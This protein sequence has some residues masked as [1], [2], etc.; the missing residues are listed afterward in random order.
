M[1]ELISDR[2]TGFHVDI[3]DPQQLSHTV[4]R[5]WSRPLETR[6]M[7]RAARHHVLEHYSSQSNYNRL[8]AIYDAARDTRPSLRA[9]E[10]SK[11][12]APTNSLP[13]PD[14]IDDLSTIGQPA[15]PYARFGAD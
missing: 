7:G 5:A 13:I 3:D 4:C 1:R 11:I 6:E 14:L 2:R 12:V 10:L 8:T 9:G 15:F